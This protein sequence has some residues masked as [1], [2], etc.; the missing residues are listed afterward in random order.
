MRCCCQA[1]TLPY[2][3]NLEGFASVPINARRKDGRG[4]RCKRDKEGCQLHLDIRMDFSR[5]C[6]DRAFPFDCLPAVEDL[7]G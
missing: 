5:V 6:V 2:L 4:N 7:S 3:A 1:K